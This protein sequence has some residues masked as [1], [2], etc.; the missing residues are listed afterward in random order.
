M[1]WQLAER[2]YLTNT[3]YSTVGG[4][5]QTFQSLQPKKEKAIDSQTMCPSRTGGCSAG[6]DCSSILS[7]G[8]C[9]LRPYS[10]KAL[11]MFP[12]GI[13][14]RNNVSIYQR[15]N[16]QHNPPGIKYKAHSLV[17]IATVALQTE[18]NYLP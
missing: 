4:C 5:F 17:Q 9:F 12:N 8:G 11:I 3:A 18:E 10:R 1:L 2:N 13:T 15:Y 16:N 14:T 7:F 6:A